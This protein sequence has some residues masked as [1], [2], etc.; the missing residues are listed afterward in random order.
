MQ[1]PRARRR[2]ERRLQRYLDR[3]AGDLDR[4]GR[5]L[6]ARRAALDELE[7]RLGE[8]E[9]E[10]A[11]R[12]ERLE[13]SGIDPAREAMIDELFRHVDEW[14]ELATRH[15][16]ARVALEDE[17]REAQA[18][19]AEPEAPAA[20]R[21]LL[22]VLR[23]GGYE[24][25]EADGAPPAPGESVDLGADGTFVVVRAG[26]SPLPLDPTPCVFLEPGWAEPTHPF[27]GGVDDASPAD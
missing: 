8:R 5:E 2:L 6:E 7:A 24:L 15:H 3:S 27:E 13:Q 19:R 12:N 21:H 17:L 26:R 11:A 22:F 20:D 9:R 18:A 16:R 23:P 25:R 4:R 14:R 1:E 10:L